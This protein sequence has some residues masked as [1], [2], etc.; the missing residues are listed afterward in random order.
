MENISDTESYIIINPTQ[1]QAK[2]IEE[3]TKIMESLKTLLCGTSETEPKK[4]DV[5]DIATQA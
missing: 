1:K 3:L 4:Q 5:L 2:A